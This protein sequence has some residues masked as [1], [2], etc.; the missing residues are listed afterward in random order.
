[1]LLLY[2]EGMTHAVSPAARCSVFKNT[3]LYVL[4]KGIC[5]KW[6]GKVVV[7]TLVFAPANL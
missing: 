6:M 3:D 1:M 5:I 2:K 7:N 4:D